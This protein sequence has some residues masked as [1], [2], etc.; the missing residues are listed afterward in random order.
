MAFIFVSVALGGRAPL[1]P[2]YH[3]AV[4]G[5]PYL[6]HLEARCENHKQAARVLPFLTDCVR[7]RT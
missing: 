5:G 1:V 7:Y 6:L 3:A 4:L 2:A